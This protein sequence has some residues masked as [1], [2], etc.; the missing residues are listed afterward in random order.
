MKRALVLTLFLAGCGKQRIVEQKVEPPTPVATD[1]PI[2]AALRDEIDLSACKFAGSPSGKGHVTLTLDGH[3]HV[4]KAEVDDPT[5]ANTHAGWCVA[6]RFRA[7][8]KIDP[9][10]YGIRMAEAG[11]EL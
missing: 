4:T 6:D 1:E 3:N 2:H 10:G 7:M 11:F 8:T 5:F 9:T